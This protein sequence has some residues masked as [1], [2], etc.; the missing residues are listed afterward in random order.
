MKMK[1]ILFYVLF[2]CISVPAFSQAEVPVDSKSQKKLQK[3]ARKAERDE[4][5]SNAMARTKS[6]IDSKSFVLEANQLSGR[7]GQMFQVNPS[8]NFVSVDSNRCVIQLGSNTGVGANGVGGVTAEGYIS[9]YKVSQNKKGDSFTINVFTNTSIGAFDLIFF[10]D[11]EG[12]A[13]AD[14]TQSTTGASAT[15]YGRIVPLSQ[16]RVYKGRSI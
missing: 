16:S 5:K 14:V 12:N 9:K 10:I 6:L 3:E 8:I 11:P 1:K 15:Y 13:Q 7:S 2:I 4:A